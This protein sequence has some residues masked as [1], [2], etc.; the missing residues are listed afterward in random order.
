MF[1]NSERLAGLAGEAQVLVIDQSVLPHTFLATVATICRQHP[2][3]QIIATGNQLKIDDAVDLM[4]DG[5]VR[6]FPKPLVRHRIM[7]SIP[8]LL[9]R[10][11]Q[12]TDMNKEYEQ[13]HTRFS[14]LTTRE[15]DVLNYILVGTSNKAAAQLLKVS[16]RTIESRRAKVYR[17]LDANNLA[18]LVRKID[19]Q[20]SL[21][22]ELG[23]RPL[24]KA[25]RELA[26]TPQPND[27]PSNRLP[28]S[29]P[30]RLPQPVPA[31]QYA[32]V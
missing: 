28:F 25:K 15:M 30:H 18:E 13:L 20:E 17:K 24:V 11:Q 10:V 21:G 7:S 26:P 19:R 4:K 12:L 23:G 32:R 1:H 2:R 6:V 8:E 29:S 5:A 16:V 22:K 27:Q 14:K 31:A 3:V 9:Q